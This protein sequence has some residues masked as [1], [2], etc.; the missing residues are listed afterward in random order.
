MPLNESFNPF[1]YNNFW[2]FCLLWTLPTLH[3]TSKNKKEKLFI[4]C[5]VFLVSLFLNNIWIRKKNSHVHILLHVTNTH[6]LTSM[7][8]NLLN[9]CVMLFRVLMHGSPSSCLASQL[10]LL[11][12]RIL[13]EAGMI[14]IF[15][16]QDTTNKQGWLVENDR[17]VE[18][19]LS[20]SVC[21][22][23]AVF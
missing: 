14:F 20:W 13:P 5:F 15:V 6:V 9:V 3:D 4:A 8:S 1:K 21:S 12:M 2:I 19:S 10:L 7:Y 18:G 11:G 17:C 23:F 22:W 16:I